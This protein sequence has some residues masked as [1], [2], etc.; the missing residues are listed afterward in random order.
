[1]T[2]ME[3]ITT[4]PALAETCKRLALQPFVTVDTE[5]LREST[6]YPQLCVVQMASP[7]DAVVIDALA[8]GLDLEPFF[9]LMGDARPADKLQ[10]SMGVYPQ[11]LLAHMP[12]GMAG[13]AIA[14]MFAAAQGSLDSAINAMASSAITTGRASQP[15]TSLRKTAVVTPNGTEMSAAMP[16]CSSVPVIA[17][18][19]P[20]AFD[21]CNGPTRRWSACWT[22]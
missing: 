16:T 7:K 19:P 14:G 17:A 2:P 22:A 20:P 10:A 15:P 1:M 4:T 5:F 3:P 6:Y 12:T 13:L 8:E 18:D 9:E 21:D 11:F